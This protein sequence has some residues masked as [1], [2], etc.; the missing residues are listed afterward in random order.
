MDHYRDNTSSVDDA[1]IPS[2]SSSC[3]VQISDAGLEQLPDWYFCGESPLYKS[4]HVKQLDISKN[5]FLTVPPQIFSLTNLVSIDI[6]NNSL[7][8][9]PEEICLLKKLRHLS[10]RNNLLEGLPKSLV[11][12]NKLETVNF[13]GNSLD[14]IPPVL[15]QMPSLRMVYLGANHIET[16]P[17]N[18]EMLKCVEVLY[19]GGNRLT[20]IPATIGHLKQLTSLSLCGNRLETIPPTLVEL[21]N[22]QNL[23][24]HDNNLTAL[25]TEIVKLRNL[26][27]LSL[28][29]N[30][31]V[32]QFVHDM[33]FD[34]PSLKE[35]AA[36]T[37]RM[38]VP[39]P[40]VNR[41]LPREILRYINTA[42]QC[43]NPRCKGVYFEAC[44]EH[45]KFVDFCGKYR[46]PLLQYL[47]SPRCTSNNPAYGSSSD[48]S[49]YSDT[50]SSRPGPS[51]DL[52]MKKVL[53]G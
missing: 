47:C 48:Y 14:R 52:K 6:S 7:T 9:I 24:L 46:V 50:E 16:L 1:V 5:A 29:N 10:A 8:S 20:D 23:A 18:F 44:V 28:R 37:V 15:L 19:L 27:H 38:R 32:H 22:L 12:L 40:I 36:R 33:A 34:P 11:Q 13:S 21:Q 25:P 51:S 35:L 53:L 4:A 26:R 41:V 2:S 49:D 30:P 39:S 42:S 17:Y 45:V 31:L 3:N 43:V